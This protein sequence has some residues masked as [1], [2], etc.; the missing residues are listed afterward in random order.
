MTASHPISLIAAAAY[1][2]IAMAPCPVAPASH[3]RDADPDSVH[4]A[5]AEP[6]PSPSLVAPCLCGCDHSGATSGVAKR[7]DTVLPSVP[8]PPTG[9]VQPLSCEISAR[10]PDAPISVDSPVPIAT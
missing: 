8:P 1:L 7:V 6:G 5:R 9:W 4:D 3:S 10:L 2:I